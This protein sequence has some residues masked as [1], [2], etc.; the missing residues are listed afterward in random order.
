MI[1]DARHAERREAGI[2]LPMVITMMVVGLAIILAISLMTQAMKNRGN[3]TSKQLL[4]QASVDDGAGTMLRALESRM[5]G[6]HD[7]FELT[8]AEARQLTVSD[9]ATTIVP[10]SSLP[11]DLGRV[12]TVAP[13]AVPPASRFTVRRNLGNGVYSYWQI[14]SLAR[15]DWR[16]PS[17]VSGLSRTTGSRVV[18][19]FRG[20]TSD[21]NNRAA[22][23][24]RLTRAE[25]RPGRFADYELIV[26]GLLVTRA[27]SGEVSINGPVHSNGMSDRMFGAPLPAS[28]PP[29]QAQHGTRCYSGAR[30]S[31]ARGSV[32]LAGSGGCSPSDVRENTGQIINL[33]TLDSTSEWAWK[34]LCH[35]TPGTYRSSDGSFAIRCVSR[36]GAASLAPQ[37]VGALS[38]MAPSAVLLVDG[39]VH[40]S[41]TVPIGRRVSV[42]AHSRTVS[43]IGGNSIYVDH[44]VTSSRDAAIGLFA[45]GDIIAAIEGCPVNRIDGALIA[46]SGTLSFP[47][48][49]RI[50]VI[51]SGMMPFLPTCPKLTLHGAIATHYMPSLNGDSGA[52]TILGW[53]SRTLSYDRNLY[54]A[55]PPLVPHTASWQQDGY[56][57]ANKRCFNASSHLV[58]GAGCR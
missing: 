19:Y 43:G 52:A 50:P 45:G 13:S 34:A 12:D 55:P 58:G 15:P 27:N 30:F 32:S 22:S 33:K 36:A 31:T 48:Q 51:T 38:A 18:V 11:G 42:I 44:N 54:N 10:N 40:V 2:A 56:D 25:Y 7:G 6:E 37:D 1:S 46:A 29:I 9:A 28:A 47:A 39:D 3:A 21:A 5:V 8:A 57:E 49:W 23:H 17:M 35:D 16:Q 14:F 4:G 26:D 24:T 53:K 41:G 20:W